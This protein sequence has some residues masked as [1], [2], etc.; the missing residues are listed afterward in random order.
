MTRHHLHNDADVAA[1]IAQNPPDLDGWEFESSRHADFASTV[2]LTYVD[3]D[4][5]VATFGLRVVDVDLDERRV[6]PE[7]REYEK[8]DRW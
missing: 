4:G 1:A 8:G 7:P 5:A 2:L 3:D 6:R